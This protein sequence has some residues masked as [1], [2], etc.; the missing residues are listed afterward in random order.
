MDVHPDSSWPV[1]RYQ[2]LW[3]AFEARFHTGRSADA[4]R[5]KVRRMRLRRQ[6]TPLSSST[7]S[8]SLSSSSSTLK[9]AATLPESALA[10]RYSDEQ[11]EF[12]R[13]VCVCVRADS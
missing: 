13:Q 10:F 4:L 5:E 1:T 8:S 12:L 11:N 6:E 3:A 9:A 7:S 2:S